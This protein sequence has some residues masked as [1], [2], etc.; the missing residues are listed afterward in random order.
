MKREGEPGHRDLVVEHVHARN[1]GKGAAQFLHFFLCQDAFEA[2]LAG[3]PGMKF[4]RIITVC[5]QTHA[6]APKITTTTRARNA[7]FASR[8][9]SRQV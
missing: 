9:L 5:S 7:I 8:M 2:D 3:R 1:E 6:P 4:C